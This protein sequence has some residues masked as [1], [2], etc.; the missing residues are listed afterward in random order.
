MLES[1][2]FHL[3][4]TVFFAKTF[5]WSIRANTTSLLFVDWMF[6]QPWRGH[7]SQWS[8]F[9]TFCAGA[10]YG[11]CRGSWGLWMESFSSAYLHTLLVLGSSALDLFQ[12]LWIIRSFCFPLIP[13]SVMEMIGTDWESVLF[14]IRE[15]QLMLWEGVSCF[16]FVYLNICLGFSVVLHIDNIIFL[17]NKMKC[18]LILDSELITL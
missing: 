12:S 10:L 18:L 9:I 13:N 8:L 7:Y 14:L 3:N 1:A 15:W 6:S 5:L 4:I 11:P 17:Q 2:D 16:L